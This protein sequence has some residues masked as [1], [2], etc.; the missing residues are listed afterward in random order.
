M[1]RRICTQTVTCIEI[2][3]KVKKTV[4][5]AR[6]NQWWTRPY[7]PENL[8]QMPPGTV[9]LLIR[10]EDQYACI[11]ADPGNRYPVNIAFSSLE[12]RL[13]IRRENQQ[14]KERGVGEVMVEACGADP[15]SCVSAVMETMCRMH[16]IP[17]RAARRYPAILE[18]IGWCTW[19][20]FYK[21]VSAEKIEAKLKEIQKKQ[22]PIGWVLIDDGWL[23]VHENKLSGLD[24]DVKKFPGGLQQITEEI[25]AAGI[26]HVGVWHTLNGYWDGIEKNS[27]LYMEN[28]DQFVEADSGMVLPDPE[29]AQEDFFDQWYRFLKKN[30]IDFTKADAQSSLE[31]QYRGLGTVGAAAESVHALLDHA[32]NTHFDGAL[33]NCMGMSPENIFA[34]PYSAVSRNSDDFVPEREGGFEE[35]LLQNAFNSVYHNGI[36]YCDWDMF[37]SSHPEAGK[38]ALIRA[39]S[40]GPV[41][42]SD[43][44]GKTERRL[45]ER[46]CYSD[47]TVLRADYAAV[48][49]PDCLFHDPQDTGFLKIFT[50]CNQ[51][52]CI[53]VFSFSELPVK[54]EV[55][56]PVKAQSE[57]YI[58][59]DPLHMESILL[60]GTESFACE[61][62]GRGYRYFL[63]TPVRNGAAV[64][65]NVDKYVASHPVQVCRVLPGEI[66]A[67][68]RE[69]G[70]FAFY[71]AVGIKEVYV[72][73]TKC[74]CEK[75][76]PK[77]A[78]NSFLNAEGECILPVNNVYTLSCDKQRTHIF[79]R[80]EERTYEVNRN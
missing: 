22:I 64:I 55:A 59:T 7:F 11:A 71:S 23:S 37:W 77:A 69:G 63:F 60:K 66:Q 27:L 3:K 4:A 29:T 35:H 18:K 15:Y 14:G 10:Y 12:N 54:T 76:I 57:E 51:T 9:L 6:F 38:H 72:N 73:N 1:E 28:R 65:G 61:V 24:A 50:E 41:Y 34:R 70:L 75:S 20:A 46:L 16:N 36:Y 17:D 44:V 49:T 21:E 79:L 80:T 13:F 56:L 8:S 58:V 25:K 32:A 33:I 47:G 68:L 19:D 62:P 74:I 43:P 40:G 42:I 67:E 26:P 78:G 31:V 39:L 52:V 48:P 5:F 53:G 45:L 30:G 2:T